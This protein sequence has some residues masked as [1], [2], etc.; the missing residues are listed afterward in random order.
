MDSSGSRDSES[1][2]C[3]CTYR[4]EKFVIQIRT[5]VGVYINAA[6]NNLTDRHP[7][8]GSHQSG[9]VLGV[10]NNIVDFKEIVLSNVM[11][12]NKFIYAMGSQ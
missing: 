12:R 11:G 9:N 6:T 5:P 2:Q 10:Q 1:N 4:L 7:M 8:H 3:Q